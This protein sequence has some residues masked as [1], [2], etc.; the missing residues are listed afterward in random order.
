MKRKQLAKLLVAFMVMLAAVS[1]LVGCGDTSETTGGSDQTVSTEATEEDVP[2]EYKNAL[3][4]AETYADMDMSKA[5]IYDQLTSEYGEGF[6]EDAA[7]YA[8][9][10]VEAD[11]NQNALGK[12]EVYYKDMAMSKDAVYEQLVSDYGEKFTE[13]QAQYAIDHLE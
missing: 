6:P 7:Q 13:E 1:G 4:K 11:W 9:D 10:N 12:A 8:I 2:Q 5:G 3:R